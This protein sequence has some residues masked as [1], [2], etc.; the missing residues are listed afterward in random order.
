MGAGGG[1]G[2]GGESPPTARPQFCR[3]TELTSSNPILLGL[4]GGRDT[5]TEAHIGGP[6]TA[7]KVP[8]YYE[9]LLAL[10]KVTLESRPPPHSCPLG[11]TP[12]RKGPRRSQDPPVSIVE[13]GTPRLGGEKD[14]PRVRE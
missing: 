5:C 7:K 6:S 14:L 12:R 10:V 4:F 9:S 2:A 3:L 8:P 13:T 11:R 1:G